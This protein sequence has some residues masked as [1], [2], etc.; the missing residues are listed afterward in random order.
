[1]IVGSSMFGKRLLA[2]DSYRC[3]ISD[4]T[5]KQLKKLQIDTAVIPRGCTE[6]IQAPD[7]YCNAPFKDK[8]RH[9]YE[10]WMLHGEKSYTKSG[11]MRAPSME[12]YL[13]WIGNAWD[14][15]SKDLIIKSFKGCRLTNN[16]DGSEDCKIHCFRSD[17]PIQTGQE[18]LKQARTNAD[19]SD[20]RELIQQLDINAESNENDENSD[21]SLD[22]YQ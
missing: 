12:V 5:K 9:F 8:A 13:K 19:I 2:W 1:M 4:A 15:L 16:L 17:S 20:T 10:N 21:A 6:F 3:H 11:N 22:F 18:L 7:V 14:Q